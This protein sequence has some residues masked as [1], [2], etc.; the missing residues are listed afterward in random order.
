VRGFG[1]GWGVLVGVGL[2]FVAACA[3]G[4]SAAAPP[5]GPIE[6]EEIVFAP[7]LGVD[8]GAMERT[9][10]GLYLQD[11]R[12]GGGFAAQRT[13]LVAVRYVGYLPD[14]TIFDATGDGEPFQFRLGSNE[15]IRGWNQGIPG[16]RLGGIRR[17][18]VRAELGYGSR[19]R[20]RIPPNTT[21][22]FDVQLVDV[23]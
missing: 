1:H 3:G 12:T 18:I 6:P 17:L 5:P 22:I 10:S 2:L 23:R 16:M 9:P 7:E 4:G 13:S 14:G 21:T 19:G 8:L 15:V 20:G 11:L